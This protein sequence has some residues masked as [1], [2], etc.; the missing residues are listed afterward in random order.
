MAIR[1]EK[2]AFS[3]RDK[4]AELEY[5]TIPYHKMPAGTPIQFR[6][7][8]KVNGTYSSGSNSSFTDVPSMSVTITPRFRDSLMYIECNF[9]SIYL[10]LSNISGAYHNF[11]MLRVIDGNGTV[12]TTQSTYVDA[13]VGRTAPGQGFHTARHYVVLDYPGSTEEMTYKLQ[14][15]DGTS[16]HMDIL[17]ND[18]NST[19]RFAVW[20]IKQ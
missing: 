2:P 17:F 19:S 8:Y 1:I 16:T 13:E 11:R 6:H 14:H 12:P 20:G 3:L 15:K 5:G 4:L 7:N 10:Q 18:T 9:N